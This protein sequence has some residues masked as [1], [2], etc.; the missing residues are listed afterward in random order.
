MLEANF[1]NDGDRTS[2]LSK[3]IQ[4]EWGGIAEDS[5]HVRISYGVDDSYR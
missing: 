2:T 3:Q 4:N 5:A 1:N